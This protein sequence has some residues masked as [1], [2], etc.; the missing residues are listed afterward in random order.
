MEPPKENGKLVYVFCCLMCIFVVL[1]FSSSLDSL[2]QKL[3]FSSPWRVGGGSGVQGDQRILCLG[4]HLGIHRDWSCQA[5]GDNR[6]GD[7]SLQVKKLCKK[8]HFPKQSLVFIHDLCVFWVSHVLFI[9][10]CLIVFVCLV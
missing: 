3:C 10:I 2:A 7:E 5:W 9:S 4:N 8:K 1:S 6:S